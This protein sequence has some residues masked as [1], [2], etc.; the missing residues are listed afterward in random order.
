MWLVVEEN[1]TCQGKL[2]TN[3]PGTPDR[4]RVESKASLPH[5]VYAL[6]Y[7]ITLS[8]YFDI[9]HVSV[10]NVITYKLNVILSNSISQLGFK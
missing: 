4:V 10:S 2:S 8:L 3:E 6:V 9:I 1:M 7:C 5:A